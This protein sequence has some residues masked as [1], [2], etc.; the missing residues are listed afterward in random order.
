MLQ[1][2]LD[3]LL[4]LTL[5]LWEEAIAAAVHL[6]AVAA[7]VVVAEALNPMACDVPYDSLATPNLLLLGD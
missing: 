5:I 1:A 7:V 4:L 2:Y 3:D 6:V